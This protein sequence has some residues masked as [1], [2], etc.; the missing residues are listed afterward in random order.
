MTIDAE[1]G[2]LVLSSVKV[3]NVKKIN[4]Y[5]FFYHQEKAFAQ[6]WAKFLQWPKDMKVDILLEIYKNFL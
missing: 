4:F 5:R 6:S 3:L 1:R 2:W